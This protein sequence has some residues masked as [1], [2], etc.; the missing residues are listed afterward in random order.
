M[1]KRLVWFAAGTAVGV[2]GARRAE[3]AVRDQVARLAPANVTSSVSQ[4]AKDFG[5]ELRDAVADGK[6]TMRAEQARLEAGFPK[7]RK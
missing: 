4:A 6:A 2:A 5:G 7:A 1:F 3:R